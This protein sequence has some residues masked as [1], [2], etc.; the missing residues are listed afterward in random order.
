MA[1]TYSDY[2]FELIGTGEQAGT[3]GATTN[4]NLGTAIEQAIGGKADITMSSTSET[5]TLTNTNAAQDARAL[6]LNLSGTPGG[7]ATLNVPA[8][9]KAYIVKNGTNQAVTVKV[10][11]QTGVA[12]PTGKTMHL[13]NNGTDVVTALDNL[14]AGTTINN[15]AIGTVTSVSGTG[16]V[17]GLTLTGTVT[18]SGNLTLG[19][20]L[21]AVN[22][23]SQVT[24][25]LP[26]ANGGTAQSTYTTGD[27]L[28]A[29][30][31]N[32][33]A[34]RGIGSTGQ[35]LT[36]TGGV[37]TWATP[38][39]GDVTSVT[40]SSPLAS[41]GGSTPNISFTGTLPVANGGTG[42]TSYT[43]GQLLIG[44]TSGNT[45]TK[46]TLTAGAG[47]SVT[48][49]AGSITI[50]ST[51]TGDVVG[52]ASSTDNGIALFDS[53]TG[54][55]L[56]D[57]ASQD[58]FVY[59][60]RLGR[61]PGGQVSNTVFGGSGP[62]GANTTGVFNT[63]IGHESLYSNTSG[64]RNTAIGSG[65]L[66][67]I[68]TGEYNTGIG[69]AVGVTTAAGGSR[70]TYVGVA[71]GRGGGDDNV[72]LGYFA[73]AS[74]SSPSNA[75]NRIVIGVSISGQGDNY[76]TFGKAGNVVYNQFTVNN[77]WTRSSDE[78]LKRNI[79]DD[80]LG[81]SFIT[82]LRPVTFQ[83]KPSNEV[84]QELTDHYFEENKMDLEA[85]M[86]GF[87]AQDVKQAL[88]E[89]GAGTQG[90]WSVEKDSTQ[91]VSREM[92]IMPLVNAVKE[93]KAEI[94]TLKA[95]IATLKGG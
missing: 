22:L 88:D 16:T 3:W 38:A 10:T 28:Y 57:S 51:A 91:A 48:N 80:T 78:R 87:I 50:A 37:P 73:D 5:L 72:C 13:Y 46:A 35:V 58:G 26:S 77:S 41:S 9:E 19:G 81:L 20:S 59:G 12:I 29:S 42:Q 15:A 83:W 7:A 93:L 18:S 61:G 36:V 4:T 24:G 49:G 63:V 92:F 82:K 21:S 27:L 68:T 71:A 69:A 70:N 75:A 62:M 79:Q 95:E 39:A 45:L 90:V 74:T 53:T 23:A 40:A 56:K 85:T 14:P 34:K 66:Q 84:P 33:L 60:L 76:F 43:N 86:N 11:G 6:Y 94:D 32:T 47:I 31:T 67:D 65:A 30:G 8:I 52:P 55:L 54:K 25:T 17:Q 89:V 64:T 1:S 44:N 2:K